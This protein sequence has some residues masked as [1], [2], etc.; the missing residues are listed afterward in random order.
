MNDRLP[1][2]YNLASAEEDGELVRYL[3]VLLGNWKLI[4]SV[5]AA[6][7]FLGGV[8]AILATPIYEAD[9]LI[10][11]EDSPT[12]ASSLLGDV[13]QLFDTKTQAA[14]EIE[15]LRSRMVVG[16]A[17]DNLRLYIDAKPRYFPF[18]GRWIASRNKGISD[19]GIL[20]WGGYVWGSE[21]IDVKEFNVPEELEG[22]DFVLTVLPNG[23]FRLEQPDLDSPIE[24][25]LGEVTSVTQS[26]G[27][28]EISVAGVKAKPLARFILIRNSQLKTL[29]ELQVNL[30]IE[31]KGKQSGII[32]ASL[33]GKNPKLTSNILNEIGHEY[34]Q[35]NIRRKGEEAEKSIAFLE[36]LMPEL[37]SQ[38]EIS[39]NRFNALRNS[40]GTFNLSEEGAA[41]L[42]QSVTT[43][44]AL[45]EQKQKLTELRSRFSP[46]HPAVKAVE[47]QVA[48]LNAK[49]TSQA[50]QMRSLP[51][52][53]QDAVRL[54]RD[55]QVSNDLYVGVLN[56]MQQL[57]LVKAGKVGTVRQLDEARIPEEPVK[58]KR[59]L[60]M[61]VAAILG[62]MLGV[63]SAFVR[64]TIFGGVTSAQDIEQRTGLNVYATIPL[65]QAQLEIS[66]AIGA[67]KS[68]QHL[69]AN[70]E[71]DEASIEALRSFRTAL[72]FAMLDAQN[73]RVLLTGA[74]PSVGKSF[75]SA[76]LAAVLAAGGKR[77][78]LVDADM[79]K[80]YL[81]Q[82][83]GLERAPGL[84]DVLSGNS[85]PEKVTHCRVFHNLD[86][87]STGAIPP[88][89]ADLL[90]ND[91]LKAFLDAKSSKYDIV[92]VDSPPVLA[93][94]DASLAAGHCGTVF[95]IARSNVTTIGEIT[96]S[97]KS[98]GHSNASIKGVIFNGVDQS[99][100]TY[101]SKYGRYRY[102]KYEYGNSAGETA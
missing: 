27:R 35:Q 55:V 10:Q 59:A 54:M 8:Y 76:N 97:A 68:G 94:S 33:Q 50:R 24:G 42:Q 64:E 74:T 83:F 84:S 78:L 102:V 19:P 80:G 12:S 100:F 86:F 79:R 11:V 63:I 91:R 22:E 46:D 57:K 95:V 65:S 37:K 56:N 85:S 47:Q 90:S 58:P 25:K 96:E 43:Q 36:K 70:L 92:L 39:E 38:L 77:V 3:D 41:Y 14:A 31:E 18:I 52:L 99:A 13:S 87:I 69:L 29:Q 26:V 49:V 101:G 98:L 93:V 75:V 71:P 82:Y 45:F 48:A 28:I 17:V 62:L 7:I 34:V 2:Q 44:T 16:K 66:K 60:V 23:R 53:E 15:I 81:N 88:N 32:D 73:N 72:Q 89:P 6:A 5:L 4:A 20:G 67:K 61:A 21:S 30:R 40:R 9:V 51:N 1:V